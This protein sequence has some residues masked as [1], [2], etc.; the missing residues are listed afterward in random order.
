[1]VGEIPGTCQ[2]VRLAQKLRRGRREDFLVS[3]L[4]PIVGNKSGNDGYCSNGMGLLN[5]ANLNEVALQLGC[6]ANESDKSS[7]QA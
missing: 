5:P 4:K 1:M 7:R 3:L 6:H 2:C